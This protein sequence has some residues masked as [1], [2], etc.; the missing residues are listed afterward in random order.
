[1]AYAETPADLFPSMSEDG[2][3]LTI[4]I[5]GIP[6]LTAAEADAATG[7]ARK[8]VYALLHRIHAWY[9]G[10]ADADKPTK[11]TVTKSGPSTLNGVTKTTFVVEC[12]MDVGS[13]DV[14]A[15]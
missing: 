5:A 14:D 1:M 11:I 12:T 8:L 7:D 6:Q 4:P 13:I 3:N 9:D 2:T 15:E 10:L